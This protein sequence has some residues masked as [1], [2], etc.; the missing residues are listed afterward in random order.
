MGN[1]GWTG[2]FAG[3]LAERRDLMI[4]K[5]DERREPSR[6]K[7]LGLAYDKVIIAGCKYLFWL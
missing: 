1:F 4:D 6:S 7:V 5:A 3:L 2:G